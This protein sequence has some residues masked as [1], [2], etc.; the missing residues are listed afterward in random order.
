MVG[1]L[2]TCSVETMVAMKVNYSVRLTVILL[3]QKTDVH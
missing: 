3:F 2:E 1:S